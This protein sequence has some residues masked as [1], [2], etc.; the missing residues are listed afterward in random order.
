MGAAVYTQALFV[1][2]DSAYLRGAG[3]MFAFLRTFLNRRQ[4]VRFRMG[5]VEAVCTVEPLLLLAVTYVVQTGAVP[6]HWAR[7]SVA[8]SRP[9]SV[10][11][12]R[13]PDG[14]SSPGRSSPGAGS[15]PATA[16]SPTIGW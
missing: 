13:S 6:P 15:L 1:V 2:A 16:C 7:G 4:F 8:S 10:P 9:S 5:W 3:V 11:R 14:V 12:W